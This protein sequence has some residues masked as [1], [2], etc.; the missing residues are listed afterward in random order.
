[1]IFD[2]KETKVK[3]HPFFILKANFMQIKDNAWLQ[4]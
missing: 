4:V 2:K 3:Y 1:M